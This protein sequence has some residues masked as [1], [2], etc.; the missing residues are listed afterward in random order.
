M[1]ALL[2]TL[3]H[4]HTHT[5]KYAHIHMHTHTCIH[6]HT[7]TCMLLP[8]EQDSR[9]VES[10]QTVLGDLV[11]SPLLQQ[12]SQ[13]WEDIGM[14]ERHRHDRREAIKLHLQNLLEEM[15]Q[16][17]TLTASTKL[18]F[19]RTKTVVNLHRKYVAQI[20]MLGMGKIASFGVTV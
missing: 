9:E 3:T 15:L 8:S 5:C 19:R 14:E 17:R 13:V 16:V 2:P 7:H 4:T 20:A 1:L 6:T 12:F 18:V 11:S 10:L